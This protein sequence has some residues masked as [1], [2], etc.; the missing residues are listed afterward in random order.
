MCNLCGQLWGD[1]AAH[2]VGSVSRNTKCLPRVDIGGNLL[3]M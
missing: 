1:K 2:T 3:S